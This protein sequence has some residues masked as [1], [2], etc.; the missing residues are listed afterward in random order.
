MKKFITISS[1][2]T[3]LFISSNT[4]GQS[5]TLNMDITYTGSLELVLKDA[6]KISAW[7]QLKESMIEMTTIKYTLIP[8]KQQ[9]TIEPKPIAAAKVNVEEK[10]Q[11]L[12]RGYVRGGFGVYTTPLLDVYYMDGRSRNGVWGLD[13]HH[14]SSQGG[15]AVEDSITDSFSN[16]RFGMWGR[17]Y[18][19]KHSIEGGINWNRDVVHYYGFDP[20]L[21]WDAPTDNLKQRF[22]NLEGYVDL[23]SYYRD[24]SKV[25]Y[26][27]RLGFRNFRDLNDG[28]E[29]N[30]DFR[31]NASKYLNSELFSMDFRVNYNDFQYLS[32]ADGKDKNRSNLLVQL[33]PEARTD[34]GNLR[35]RL[36]MGLWLDARSDRAFRFYPIAEAS[37]S[38]LDDLFIP[39]AG[40]E[41]SPVQ[42]TYRSITTENPFVLSDFDVKN[43]NRRLELF[44]GIRGTLSS[45]TS[46]NARVSTT[47]YE[48]FLYFVNDST[49]SP[50]SRFQ[51]LYDDLS[52]FTLRGEVAI[53]TSDKFRML[54]R[55]EYFIYST[56]LEKYA[57]YQPSTKLTLNSSYNIGDKFLVT[58]DA[59]TVGQR[60]AKSLVQHRDGELQ[61]DGSYTVKLKGYVDASLGIEYRYTNRISAWVKFNNLLFSR[62]QQWNLYNIQRFNAMMGAT[63][64]F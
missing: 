29:N 56:D 35:V 53:S 55:G 31:G 21:N 3:M 59:Y 13:Y 18:L 63:Y 32:M 58:L 10:L 62:Y 40:V 49:Y 30:V 22:N 8:S 48:D 1:A 57:W 28:V 16:N 33:Q 15:G 37:Y 4:N 39:Y 20:V 51:A 34:V 25:N 47:R 41:G 14:L 19:S 2:L 38:I 7:P 17:R 43:T 54:A 45:S 42:N 12:Y 46:F 26:N 24:S 61:P 27:G 50:G 11:K 5:D 23:R 36:G 6:N 60:R 44:G 52:V 9:V 64:S